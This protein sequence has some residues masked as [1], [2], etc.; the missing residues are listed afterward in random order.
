[1]STLLHLYFTSSYRATPYA[2]TVY[3]V[4]LYLSVPLYVCLSVCLSYVGVLS[5]Q[6][7]VESR[8]Q[9][10]TIAWDSTF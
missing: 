2:N 1:M 6:L 10:N 5:K 3:A 8:K 7:K 4:I 9:R